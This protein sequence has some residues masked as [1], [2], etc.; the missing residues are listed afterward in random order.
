M[1]KSDEY[2]K[3]HRGQLCVHMCHLSHALHCQHLQPLRYHSRRRCFGGPQQMPPLRVSTMDTKAGLATVPSAMTAVSCICAVQHSSQE[4]NG[5][6]EHGQYEMNL[7][8]T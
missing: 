6:S 3:S 7:N 8:N 2:D 4:P 1:L 5:A